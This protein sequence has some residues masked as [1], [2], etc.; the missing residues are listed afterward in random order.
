MKAVRLDYGDGY[1]PI[2]LPDSAEVVRYGETYSD[3]PVVDP[4]EATR[5]ALERPLGFAPLREPG[6][7]ARRTVA[8][9]RAKED[10]W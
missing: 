8:E 3:P 4:H 10:R 5:T 9:S 1:R 2:D 7:E 6:R